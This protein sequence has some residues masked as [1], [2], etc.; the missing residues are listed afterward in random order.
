MMKLL[1]VI[2][3]FICGL[4]VPEV[5]ASE[6]HIRVC[7]LRP[8]DP[9]TMQSPSMLELAQ[10]LRLW[11]PRPV[12]IGEWMSE[13]RMTDKLELFIAEHNGAYRNQQVAVSCAV[14]VLTED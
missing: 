8:V 13:E 10:K 3:V 1:Y 11:R 4:V 12:R 7:R 9:A 6:S 14:L 5:H 2:C